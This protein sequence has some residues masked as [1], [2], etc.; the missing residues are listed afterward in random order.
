MCVDICVILFI[1]VFYP[2]IYDVYLF[3]LYVLTKK[4]RNSNTF[5]IFFIKI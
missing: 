3:D 4:S 1:F 5:F 2:V